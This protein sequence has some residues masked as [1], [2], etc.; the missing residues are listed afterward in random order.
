[1]PAFFAAQYREELLA[2]RGDAG[3]KGVL[4]AHRDALGVVP[5][6]EAEDVDVPP[7]TLSAFIAPSDKLRS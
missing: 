5:L 6:A 7:A 3:A 1:V 2:L 4:A